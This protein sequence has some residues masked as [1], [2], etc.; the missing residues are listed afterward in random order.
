[1][2]LIELTILWDGNFAREPDMSPFELTVKI[3]GGLAALHP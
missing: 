3:E 2:H 1:M